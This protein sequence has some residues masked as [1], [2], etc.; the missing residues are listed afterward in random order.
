VGLCQPSSAGAT[1][2]RNLGKGA[3]RPYGAGEPGAV[4]PPRHGA[5]RG[6]SGEEELTLFHIADDVV[7]IIK[8]ANAGLSFF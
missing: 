1:I 4:Q 5:R 2:Y 7:K 3:D 6:Q 8:D